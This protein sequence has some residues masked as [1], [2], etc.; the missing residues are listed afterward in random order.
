MNSTRETTTVGALRQALPYLRLFQGKSFVVKCGGELFDNPIRLKRLIEQVSVLHRLGIHIVFVHGG[1]PQTSRLSASLGR[2][3]NVVKGR[4]VTSSETLE[5]SAMVLNGQ[6]NTRVVGMLREF[7][8][9][10]VG[11]S[12]VDGDMVVAKKRAPVVVDDQAVDYGE[13][14]DV[15]KIDCDLV[16]SLL[17]QGYLPVIS[18]LSASASGELLNINADVVAAH[19]AIALSA[20]KLIL[21]SNVPGI[22]KDQNDP[23]SLVSYV[24]LAGLVDLEKEGVIR[25]GMSPKVAALREAIAGGVPRAHVI[26]SSVPDSLLSEIFTNE[27]SGTMVVKKLEGPQSIEQ[28]A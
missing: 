6:L 10:A 13:V 22:L 1:G 23:E 5:D 8:I 3:V 17:D 9:K 28:D 15:E 21:L 12:G 18:P 4:R 26:S 14:G 27:G 7:G 25:G 11:L 24:D 16:C 20:D 2:E 19:L